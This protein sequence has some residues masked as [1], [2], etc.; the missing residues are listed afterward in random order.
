MRDDRPVVTAH[1]FEAAWEAMEAVLVRD[2]LA[3]GGVG[4]ASILFT[5]CGSLAVVGV[6]AVLLAVGAA[7]LE[8]QDG[9]AGEFLA[10]VHAVAIIGGA[11]AVAAFR[12]RAAAE[13]A[14]LDAHIEA[15]LHEELSRA[16][17]A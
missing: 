13:T 17:E 5:V 6:L 15:T 11:A 4:A 16:E 8:A 2:S 10:A 12:P 3:R 7:A 9:V 14:A 1:Q